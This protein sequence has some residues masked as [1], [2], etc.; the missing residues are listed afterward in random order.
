M[1]IDMMNCG[2]SDD[3]IPA[4]TDCNQ[5]NKEKIMWISLVVVIGKYW[6]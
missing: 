4:T 3:I 6:C 1:N 2:E 5:I